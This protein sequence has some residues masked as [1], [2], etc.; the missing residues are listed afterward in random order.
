[1]GVVVRAS[2]AQGDV[3][4]VMLDPTK[5]SEIRKTR[6]CLIVSPDEINRHL[7]TVIVAPMTG[8]GGAYP[9]RVPCR[10]RRKSGFVVVDQIRT[11]DRSRL[12]RRMGRLRAETV[13]AVLRTLQDMFADIG[14]GAGGAG[15]SSMVH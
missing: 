3:Y 13:A 7:R 5:G 15:R 10:F 1:M 12:T 6:P 9:W 14:S 4:L 8:G 2:V 11:V